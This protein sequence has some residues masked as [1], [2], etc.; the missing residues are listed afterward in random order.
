MLITAG[1]LGWAFRRWRIT[2]AIKAGGEIAAHA[3]RAR[4]IREVARNWWD[5]RR[6]ARYGPMDWPG[7][8]VIGEDESRAIVRLPVGHDEGRHMLLIGATGGGKTTTLSW[9]LWRHLD[10]GCGAILIDPKG[11]PQLVER[12]RM[13]A[14]AHS[15]PFYC[16]S[17]DS[18][19]H[20]WN[21][22]AFG[23]PSEKADKLIGAEEWT[24]PH[25]KRLYQRYL[26]NLFI[27]V[28]ARGQTAHLALVVEL[29]NPDGWRCTAGR[30]T[31][32]WT[33]TDSPPTSRT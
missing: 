24:E 28:Q 20:P 5:R 30:S 13:E 6:L 31:E 11:D 8:Y 27:A 25:Y 9:A 22:L 2:S 32:K 16:F 33:P 23:T 14:L 19:R 21:P 1:L 12:A 15:R 29:L 18:P 4:T 17:L 26:L 7:T 3:R 10:A